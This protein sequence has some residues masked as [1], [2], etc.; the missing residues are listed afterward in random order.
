M[1]AFGLVM[2]LL[3][4]LLVVIGLFTAGDQ[5]AA[6]LLGIHMG[7]TTVFITG[8]IAALLIVLGLYVTRWGASLG[9]RRRAER[10]EYAKM[11]EKFGHGE[12]PEA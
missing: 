1:L 7:A 9:L 3:G 2:I 8:M 6:S 10:K 4:A 12:S 5:G 11:A